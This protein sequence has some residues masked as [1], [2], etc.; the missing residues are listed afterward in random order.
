[1]SKKFELGKR[2]PE[3]ELIKTKAVDVVLLPPR[4]MMEKV[5][6]M[7][8]ALVG[9]GQQGIPL[10][11]KNCLPHIT[12]LMGTMLQKKE[13]KVREVLKAIA[14]GFS[15]LPLEATKSYVKDET[16]IP[17]PEKNIQVS[18][19]KVEETPELIRLHAKVMEQLS[20]LLS[21]DLKPEIFASPEEVPEWMF[22]WMVDYIGKRENFN[23]LSPHITVGTGTGL[24]LTG[25]IPFTASRLAVCQHGNYFTCRQVLFA[26]MLKASPSQKMTG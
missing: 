11:A 19:L 16:E 5:I 14:Q 3:Y 1:M 6:A 23:K 15:P 10:D 25:R 24:E 13:Q 26:E 17:S 7:N 12:L 4:E 20:P 2:S 8:K 21:T 18:G 9:S 22:Q